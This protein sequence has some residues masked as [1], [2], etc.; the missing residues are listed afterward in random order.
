MRALRAGLFALLLLALVG[1]TVRALQ[2]VRADQLTGAVQRQVGAA[3][4]GGR[5]PGPLVRG[6]MAAL[7]RARELDP[8]AVEPRAFAGDLLLLSGNEAAAADAYRDAAEHEL[9]PETLLHWGHALWAEGRREEALVHWRRVEVLAPRLVADLPV[10]RD[11]LSAAPLL[12][13]P[14]P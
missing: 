10:S 2:R 8:A 14:E 4:Q 7:A 6:A 5:V 1:Q 12:P 13:M 11:E 9:R 3:R